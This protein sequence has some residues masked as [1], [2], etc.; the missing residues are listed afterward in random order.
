MT[1][2]L[3]STTLAADQNMEHLKARVTERFRELKIEPPT[4]ERVERL[5]ETACVRYEQQF[6]EAVLQRLPASTREQLDALLERYK[7]EEEE[8]ELEEE[9]PAFPDG[10]DISG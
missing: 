5:I 7:E 2:W 6:F 8:A 9:E 10:R 1:S 4:P 3:I